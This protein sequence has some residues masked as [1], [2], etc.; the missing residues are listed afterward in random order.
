MIFASALLTVYVATTELYWNANAISNSPKQSSLY[1]YLHRRNKTDSTLMSR[2]GISPESP[3]SYVNIEHSPHRSRHQRAPT[4]TRKIPISIPLCY[5]SFRYG[6]CGIRPDGSNV[7]CPEASCCVPQEYVSSISVISS[8]QSMGMCL[9]QERSECKGKEID[10]EGKDEFNEKCNCSAYE[11]KC[12][13]NSKCVPLADGRVGLQCECDAGLVMSGGKCVEDPCRG[14][15]CDPGVCMLTGAGDARCSCPFDLAPSIP[16]EGPLSCVEKKLCASDP[17]GSD[18]GAGLCLEGHSTYKCICYGG[19]SVR[20]DDLGRETCGKHVEST[21]G[22]CNGASC[23]P[24]GKCENRREGRVCVCSAG[25]KPVQRFWGGFCEHTDDPS[26][27]SSVA[28]DTTDSGDS[29]NC[30]Q[31]CGQGVILCRNRRLF[32]SDCVC[33]TGFLVV[34]GW[35][36]QYCAK[37]LGCE[38]SPCGAPEAVESCENLTDDDTIYR[39]RCHCKEGFVSPDASSKVCL[40]EEESQPWYRRILGLES[41]G[42]G[43]STT[44][45]IFAIGAFIFLLCMLMLVEFIEVRR[46]RARTPES[47]TPL[48]DEGGQ[49]SFGIMRVRDN[50]DGKQI[51]EEQEERKPDET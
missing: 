48:R 22:P 39:Y 18:N 13:A 3:V 47:N 8:S 51:S 31:S 33:D 29:T 32:G 41:I 9:P 2:N 34:N 25:Y 45:V 10:L 50:S 14:N 4:L 7:L 43:S 17:C 36:T 21:A 49:S 37:I 19:F 12:P 11:S 16:G 24:G 5:V 27:E 40:T 35:T 46:R 38:D 1:T 20:T 15:N 30:K 23:G 28:W 26:A 44:V 6:E 42:T